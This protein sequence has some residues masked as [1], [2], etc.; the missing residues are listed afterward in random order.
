[1]Q[2]FTWMKEQI[3]VKAINEFSKTYFAEETN[4]LKNNVCYFPSSVNT[5]IKLVHNY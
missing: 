5:I 1:M 4:H 2:L 3:I